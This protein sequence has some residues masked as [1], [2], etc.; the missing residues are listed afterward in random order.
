MDII[1]T[2]EKAFGFTITLL[3]V[4]LLQLDRH[5]TS[6]AYRLLM[7]IVL[8]FNQFFYYFDLILFL[9]ETTFNQ[10]YYFIHLSLQVFTSER[11]VFDFLGHQ[12][13]GILFNFISILIII[14][15][16]FGACSTFRQKFLTI[17][18][19]WQLLT[20]LWNSYIVCFHLELWSL[21][22]DKDF[23]LINLWTGRL[24]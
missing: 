7:Q 10:F 20:V 8:L 1:W 5:T 13:A 19:L 15:A 17:Y 3:C 12:W 9:F 2:Q 4:L 22:R 6:R 23:N 18:L 16:I 21:S 24:N 11:Q 14:L